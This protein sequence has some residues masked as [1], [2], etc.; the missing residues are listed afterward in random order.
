M[1]EEGVGTSSSTVEVIA[2]LMRDMVMEAYAPIT[3]LILQEVTH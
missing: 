1:E 3:C 2:N